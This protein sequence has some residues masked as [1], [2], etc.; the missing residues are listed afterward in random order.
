MGCGG[1]K[2]ATKAAAG[3]PDPEDGEKPKQKIGA[4][5]D[6]AEE[7]K[8]ERGKTNGTVRV[9]KLPCQERHLF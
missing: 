4:R 6:S 1:S 8:V 7:V 3:Q 2:P 9:R 5:D